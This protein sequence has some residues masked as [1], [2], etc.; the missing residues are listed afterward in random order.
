MAKNAAMHT[1]QNQALVATCHLHT[2]PVLRNF[3]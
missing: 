3:I 1:G 2:N